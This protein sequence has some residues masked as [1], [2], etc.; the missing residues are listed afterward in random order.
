MR[1]RIREDLLGG[2]DLWI[3]EARAN[4]ANI[5]TML[6]SLSLEKVQGAATKK[7]KAYA[8]QVAKSERAGRLYERSRDFPLRPV[9]AFNEKIEGHNVWLHY[10][11]EKLRPS[12]DEIYHAEEISRR[13]GQE[14]HVFGDT[15]TG[16]NYPGI[17]GTI[18][19]PPLLEPLSMKTLQPEST[20][21]RARYHTEQALVAARAQGYSHVRVEVLLTSRDVAEV[22][23]LWDV[24]GPGRP[25]NA[26]AELQPVYDGDIVHSVTIMCRDGVWSPPRSVPPLSGPMPLGAPLIVPGTAVPTPAS[27][28]EREQP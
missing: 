6:A 16:T 28:P 3:A 5:E 7:A 9:L 23:A 12:A 18:G 25:A 8:T 20:V 11:T 2:F 21:A 4:G 14:V 1:A 27:E 24:V 15:T 19:S 22:Q 10:Q 13:T 17:D 26:P